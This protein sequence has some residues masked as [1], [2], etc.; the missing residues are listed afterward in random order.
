MVAVKIGAVVDVGAAAKVIAGVKVGAPDD[1][2]AVA[3]VMDPDDDGAAVKVGTAVKVGADIEA[4]AVGAVEVGGIPKGG[5]AG[6]AKKL[7]NVVVAEK[8]VGN[9]G[10]FD[11]SSV[12]I[13]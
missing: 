2:R 8:P 3:E 13:G 1:V 12:E 11:W 10:A 4:W 5:T 7:A 9:V 6:A